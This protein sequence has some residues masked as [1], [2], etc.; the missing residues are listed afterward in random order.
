MP[1]KAVRACESVSLWVIYD[2]PSDYPGHFVVRRWEVVGGVPVPLPESQ[3]GLAESLENARGFVPGGAVNLGRSDGDD[4]VI[5][6]V[7]I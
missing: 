6:E 3:C 4:S 2:H 5:V 7:W 1:G